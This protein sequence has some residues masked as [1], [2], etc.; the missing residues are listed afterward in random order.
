MI[1]SLNILETNEQ[2]TNIKVVKYIK[3]NYNNKRLFYTKN[4][5]TK[6]FLFYITN[7]ILNYLEINLQLNEYDI[8]IGQ[9]NTTQFHPIS[10]YIK[11]ILGLNYYD[12]EGDKFYIN[13]LL[14]YYNK[15]T[16]QY[17]QVNYHLYQNYNMY[18]IT[19]HYNKCV[20]QDIFNELKFNVCK[21]FK[22]NIF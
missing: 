3:N 20:D 7:E 6:T 5:I 13:F 22:K 21:L 8:D 11:N 1:D 17:L 9:F 12:I 15:N 18:N 19:G 16:Y 4:N 14:D 10:S 2:Y